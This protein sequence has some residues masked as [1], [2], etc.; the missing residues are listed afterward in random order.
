MC[1]AGEIS[2]GFVARKSDTGANLHHG[3]DLFSSPQDGSH[4]TGITATVEYCHHYEWCFIRRVCDQKIPYGM[5]TKGSGGQIGTAV[6]HLRERDEA[7]NRFMDFL[8]STVR[9]AEAVQCNE[10]PNFLEVSQGVWVEDKS[11]HGLRRSSLLRRSRSKAVSP[12]MGVT[13]PLLISS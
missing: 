7:A 1:S 11:A 6:T 5:K 2:K 10:F 4:D 9:S 13:R 8:K 12:S 3:L